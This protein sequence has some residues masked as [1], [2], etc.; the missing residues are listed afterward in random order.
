MGREVSKDLGRM[1]DNMHL[2]DESAFANKGK[3]SVGVARQYS[4]RLG[5]VDN[6]QI[7]ASAA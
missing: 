3:K 4:G 2:L 5:K 1:A 6:Y 7:G